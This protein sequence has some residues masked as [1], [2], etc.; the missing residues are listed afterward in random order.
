MEVRAP[1]EQRADSTIIPCDGTRSE[2]AKIQ[3]CPLRP[4]TSR[5]S[6]PN[7]GRGC[8]LPFVDNGWARGAAVPNLIT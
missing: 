5:T 1:Y 3:L 2:D 6:T 8:T 7:V 4:G